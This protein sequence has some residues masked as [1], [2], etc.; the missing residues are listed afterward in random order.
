MCN[1]N[2]GDI[3]YIYINN[4]TFYIKGLNTFK[5]NNEFKY[6]IKIF[7]TGKLLDWLFK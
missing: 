5:L 2:A 1:D 7:N 6:R 3:E 4:N